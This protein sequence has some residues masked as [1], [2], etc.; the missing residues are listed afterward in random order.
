MQCFLT[1]IVFLV[2]LLGVPLTYVFSI[3]MKKI[4]ENQVT[5]TEQTSQLVFDLCSLI[6]GFF[7]NFHYFAFIILFL[8]NIISEVY[9]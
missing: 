3:V 5:F 9:K 7:F 2:Y 1:I 4:N 8:S 6:V